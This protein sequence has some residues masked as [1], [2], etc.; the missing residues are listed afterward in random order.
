MDEGAW[1]LLWGW[2]LTG[3]VVVQEEKR[4]RRKRPS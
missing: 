2:C 3:E 4:M 1:M